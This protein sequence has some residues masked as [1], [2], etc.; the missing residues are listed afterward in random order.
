MLEPKTKRHRSFCERVARGE[1]L[2]EAWSHSARDVGKRPG[3][4]A[5]DN[6][7]GSRN[8]AKFADWIA[9]L[10]KKEA[11]R[12]AERQQPVNAGTIANL[13]EEITA[14]LLRAADAASRSG[15]QSVA[16]SLRKLVGIHVG[17]VSRSTRD[18]DVPAGKTERVDLPKL[19]WCN[20]AGV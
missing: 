13:Q 4:R 6:V 2:G 17:R 3:S 10:K 16:T 19:E 9:H 7:S 15:S 1:P 20:C 18:A 14:V 12:A 11:E 8:A 5:A